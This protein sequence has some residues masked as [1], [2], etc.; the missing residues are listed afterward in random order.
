MKKFLLIT[1]IIFCFLISVDKAEAVGASWWQIQSIDTMKYSR[2][3]SGQI[4][5]DPTKFQ[6]LIDIQVKDIADAGATHVAIA[7]PYD[8]QFL[9]VLRMWVAAARAN[10]LKVWFRGNFSGWEQWFGYKSIGREEHKKLL[11]DFLASQ[12]DLFE[13]GDA[14]SSCPECENGGPGDP[15]HNGDADGHRKFLIEE[16]QIAKNAFFRMG[17]NVTP[18][19]MSMNG[20]VAKLIMDESTT[21]S[22]G[23]I[24]VIDHYVGSVD[25]LVSDAQD[26][27]RQSGGKVVFGEFGAPIPDIHGDMTE[28]EQAIWIDDA[29]S[30]L[31]LEKDVIGINYWVG[32]GGS[33]QLWNDG[34]TPRMAVEIIRKHFQP[35][36][37]S[38]Q[39]V[40][41]NGKAIPGIT[42]KTPWQAVQTNKEGQFV[43]PLSSEDSVISVFADG[44]IAQNINVSSQGVTD[45]EVRLE[46]SEYSLF[47]RLFQFL[48]R[49]FG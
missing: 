4:L 14:F 23:G 28:N 16:Y 15:R 35:P 44:Y 10:N 36:A 41:R 33:T 40:D 20:D 11:T 13:E 31:S 32:F 24:V 29:L 30:K 7:T 21:Q 27:A 26:Y 37:A 5:T 34:G 1:T 8:E 46:K 42:V 47:E 17:K 19:L 2:D 45:L 48:R 18:N 39:V 25:Q 12:A 22:L 38:G 49:I 9:P 43:L 3:F 6:S